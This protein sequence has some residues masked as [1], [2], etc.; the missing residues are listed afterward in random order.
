MQNLLENA[1]Y[2]VFFAEILFFRLK[3]NLKSILYILIMQYCYEQ[4]YVLVS[5]LGS[6]AL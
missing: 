4:Y 5:S 2:L 3:S 6:G 1:R